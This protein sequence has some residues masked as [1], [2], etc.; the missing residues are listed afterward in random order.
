MMDEKADEKA[1]FFNDIA[2]DWDSIKS[3]ILGDLDITEYVIPCINRND[4]V[5]D[6]GCG[7]GLLMEGILG[8]AARMIGVDKSPVML[9]MARKRFGDSSEIDLR[10]GEIEHLPMRDREADCAVINMVLHYLRSPELA[11]S[12]T[13][14]VLRDEG[15]LVIADLDK[16]SNEEMRIKYGH[17][18]LGFSRAEMEQWLSR[19]GF[20]LQEV[21]SIKVKNN[22]SVNIFKARR[23]G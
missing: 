22:M 19:S 3:G 4:T 15:C 18:W 9:E 21:R 6:L 20:E 5:A 17:L 10:I 1:S 11:I 8:R 13:G 7:T 2:P 14:R 16:H 12:E 23:P